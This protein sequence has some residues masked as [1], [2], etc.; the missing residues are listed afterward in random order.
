MLPLTREERFPMN[1]SIKPCACDPLILLHSPSETYVLKSRLCDT[2]I[3]P[4]DEAPNSP[5]RSVCVC[6]WGGGSCV[7]TYHPLVFF[8]CEQNTNMTRHLAQLIAYQFWTICEILTPGHYRS[9]HQFN[10]TGLA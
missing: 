4:I 9:G 3:K 8:A 6:V 7:I 10:L 2:G 1:W 5:Q